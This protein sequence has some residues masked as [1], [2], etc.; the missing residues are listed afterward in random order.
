MKR[1]QGKVAIVIGAGAGIA[2]CFAAEGP[3]VGVVDLRKPTC[4]TFLTTARSVD[5]HVI[6][7]LA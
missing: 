6:G 3:K 1:L 2:Q 4:D 7:S 5:N